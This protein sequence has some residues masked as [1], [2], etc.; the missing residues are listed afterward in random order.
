MVNFSVANTNV[1]DGEWLVLISAAQCLLPQWLPPVLQN[2]PTGWAWSKS[3]A[4]HYSAHAGS[5]HR[6]KFSCQSS[7][8]LGYFQ[9]FS[10]W[11][12]RAAWMSA[13]KEIEMWASLMS[14]NAIPYSGNKGEQWMWHWDSPLWYV[15]NIKKDEVESQKCF[16]SPLP[17]AFRCSLSTAAPQCS[18]VSLLSGSQSCPI[19]W[20][21]G[22]NQHLKPDSR[23]ASTWWLR[24]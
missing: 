6:V 14:A 7:R 17:L 23:H 4:V 13:K 8:M 5:G 12:C 3:G 2:S 9:A 18:N 24:I 15:L 16:S 10:P 11:H 20:G 22:R 19:I 1:P 21:F